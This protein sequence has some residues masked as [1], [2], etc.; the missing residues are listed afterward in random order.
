M[1][2][3]DSNNLVPIEA[4]VRDGAALV[5]IRLCPSTGSMNC[6]RFVFANAVKQSRRL[7]LD[8]FAAL[9]KTRFFV[10]RGTKQMTA[11]RRA[12]ISLSTAFTSPQPLVLVQQ[13]PA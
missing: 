1:I 10:P 9:A 8:C 11:H 2:A 3:L 13:H 4:I 12:I 5:M 6:L 7:K